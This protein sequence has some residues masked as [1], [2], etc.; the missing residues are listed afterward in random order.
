VTEHVGLSCARLM[1][2]DHGE[3]LDTFELMT[4]VV[5]VQDA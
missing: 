1:H 3:F 2:T 4:T 5:R